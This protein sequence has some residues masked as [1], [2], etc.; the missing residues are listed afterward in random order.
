MI[1]ITRLQIYEIKN[2]RDLEVKFKTISYSEYTY[3]K[4]NAVCID[5]KFLRLMNS[6]FYYNH[7]PLLR[8]HLHRSRYRAELQ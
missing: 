5:F 7:L 2:K 8:Y 3:K 6:I 1:N 4:I